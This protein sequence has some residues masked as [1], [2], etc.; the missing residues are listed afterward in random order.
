MREPNTEK[1]IFRLIKIAVSQ[2][3]LS[4]RGKGKVAERQR[5]RERD[6]C[7]CR[8]MLTT[9][10]VNIHNNTQRERGREHIETHMDT[11]WE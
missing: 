11:E 3:L 1:T 10:S 9:A 7:E 2:H 4:E 5:E 8:P 6:V